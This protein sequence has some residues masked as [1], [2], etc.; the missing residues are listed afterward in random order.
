MSPRVAT[1]GPSRP[2]QRRPGSRPGPGARGRGRPQ[3]A[4]RAEVTPTAP[5]RHREPVV[6]EL[7]AN[8]T[9]K[10]LADLLRVA[11]AQV[12]KA[13]LTNGVMATINQ[14]I[15]Y[16]TAA[17][18][19]SDLDFQVKEAPAPA[20]AAEE[21]P[22]LE[23]P[24]LL[25]HR[26][27]IV[28]IM[29]H[30]DH[31]KTSLLDAI[32]ETN[33]TAKEAGGI[34]QHIG[35]YQAEIRNQRITFLDTPGHEAF[36]AM[37]ARGAQV[38]DVAVLVV[39]ADD[40]VQPQ[41]IE[42]IDHAKAAKVPIIVAINKVD[43]PDAHPDRVKQQLTEHNLVVEEYGGDV[44]A[45]EVSA[46]QKKGIE[47][48]LEMILLVAEIQDLRANPNRP[49]VGAIIEAKLDKTRGPV[50]TVLVQNGTLKVGD[51]VAVGSVAGRV[52]AMFNDRGKPVRRADPS[53]PVEILGLPDVPRAGDP[54]RVTPDERTA[55]ARALEAQREQHQEV[56]TPTASTSL[57][58]IY[59]QIQAGSVKDLNLILK[60]DVQGSIDPIRSS[61]ERLSVEE[62]KVR[63][64]HEGAGNITESDVL[65][66]Q[67]SQAIILGFNVRVEP[68][69]RRAADTAN[70]DIRLY[71]IIYNV[72]EDVQKALTGMLEPVYV[73]VL[74][75]RA[76][77]RQVFKVGKGDQIAGC[78]VVE[79]K[80]SRG[81]PARL[82]RRGQVVHSS[83]IASLKRF[84]DDAREVAAGFECGVG[85]DG[86]SDVQVG[87]IIESYR[88]EKATP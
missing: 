56:A 84:K 44:V 70:V 42:A 3:S 55:R 24:S 41:T 34:T 64:L 28:T 33:V 75:G 85:L 81:T 45:V 61:L 32:R 4:R 35:A 21:A 22:E 57:E 17:I 68:G 76:E 87:D 40:G 79:G 73:E 30:V 36:T 1:R 7:P 39:A 23:D 27:P 88:R 62:V 19:A 86:F 10:D 5:L 13:L 37:R 69:A 26:P 54:L 9:V 6:V 53:T 11:P 25:V 71:S 46:K 51:F 2:P 31:G 38:T 15:D 12:I 82:L 14:T 48:L 43:K 20:V 59:A 65:L 52:R 18:V 78:M 60:T 77:V 8:M 47:H 67:A 16:E 49:A 74:E 29:G 72:I 83:Q 66:A 80:M 58:D 63:I 50:G